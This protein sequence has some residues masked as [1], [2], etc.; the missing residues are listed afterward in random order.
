MPDDKQSV[1]VLCHTILYTAFRTGKFG[2][3]TGTHIKRW[4]QSR[5]IADFI[6]E[7]GSE[8]SEGFY[9]AFTSK[10]IFN[11]FSGQLEYERTNPQIREYLDILGTLIFCVPSEPINKLK[12]N[13]GIIVIADALCNRSDYEPLIIT[14]MKDSMTKTAEVYYKKNTTQDVV[15]IPFSILN[16]EE[17]IGF[18]KGRYPGQYG[19]IKKKDSV[20]NLF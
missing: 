13:E 12:E 8:R 18:L 5:F 16:L 4:A 19:L 10:N 7:M 3:I 11:G 9:F 20:Y 14:D 17:A 6:I 1:L 15:N 2:E